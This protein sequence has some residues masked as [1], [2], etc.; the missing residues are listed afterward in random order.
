VANAV[1][2]GP[3]QQIRQAFS[4]AGCPLRPERMHPE[5]LADGFPW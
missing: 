4:A 3:P 2:S 5:M 1:E